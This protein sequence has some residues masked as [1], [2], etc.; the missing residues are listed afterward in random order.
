[1]A[2]TSLVCGR[3]GKVRH[4]QFTHVAANMFVQTFS[5]ERAAL[6]SIAAHLPGEIGVM[7]GYWRTC[8]ERVIVMNPTRNSSHRHVQS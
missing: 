3:H 4:V 6:P 1:M 8:H 5:S 2:E 7:R